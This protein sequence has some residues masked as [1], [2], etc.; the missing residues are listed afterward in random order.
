EESN[1]NKELDWQNDGMETDAAGQLSSEE[2]KPAQIEPLWL[3]PSIVAALA[4]A[5]IWA[6]AGAPLL[7]TDTDK[8]TEGKTSD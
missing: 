8:Q 4:V 7:V 5:P 2:K 3:A 1:K 6:A